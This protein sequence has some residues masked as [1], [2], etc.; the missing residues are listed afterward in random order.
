[1]GESQTEEKKRESFGPCAGLSA[2]GDEGCYK[3]KETMEEWGND[4]GLDGSRSDDDDGSGQPP[5]GFKALKAAAATKSEA[6]IDW[7]Q[8]LFQSMIGP[9]QQRG[10][11]TCS[12]I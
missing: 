9:E 4:D 2:L 3:V 6:L 5:E 7:P 11:G 1:M 12:G 8:V 10:S